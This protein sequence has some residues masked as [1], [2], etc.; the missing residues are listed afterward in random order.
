MSPFNAYTESVN[1]Q[2]LDTWVI[3]GV[4]E[5]DTLVDEVYQQFLQDLKSKLFLVSFVMFLPVLY[6]LLLNN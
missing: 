2:S 6:L 1:S 5:A 4:A 3:S